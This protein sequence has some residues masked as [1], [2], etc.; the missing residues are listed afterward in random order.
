[1]RPI[2]AA[3]IVVAC[4]PSGD[5]PPRP[6]DATTDGTGGPV[7]T[8]TTVE[9]PPPFLKVGEEG[10]VVV[11]RSHAGSGGNATFSV[12]GVFADRLKGYTASALCLAEGFCLPEGLPAE[13]DFLDVSEE[14]FPPAGADWS[15]VGNTFVAADRAVP[16]VLDAEE[17]QTFYEVRGVEQLA[18]PPYALSLGGEWGDYFDPSAVAMNVIEVTE[19]EPGLGLSLTPG[20]T[21]PFRWKKAGEGDVVLRISGDGFER[22]WRLADDG[23]FDLNVDA[24]P[25][26]SDG[27]YRVSLARWTTTTIDVNGNDLDVIGVSEQPWWAAE[28]ADF[29]TVDLLE[30]SDGDPF[31]PAIRPAYVGVGFS[32]IVSGSHLFDYSYDGVQGSAVLFFYVYDDA[33]VLQCTV[34]YDASAAVEIAADTWTPNIPG[35]EI[36]RAFDVPLANGYTDCPPTDVAFLGTDDIR[37][38]LERVDLFDWGVGIGSK[39]LQATTFL[40][41]VTTVDQFND[42]NPVTSSGWVTPNG[43]TAYETSI[44]EHLEMVPC[45]NADSD[46]PIPAATSEDLVPGYYGSTFLYLLLQASF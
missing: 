12:Y 45:G 19:P 42:L 26:E 21:I 27:E 40:K 28:C 39:S 24:V 6:T 3:L 33:F 44:I 2:V 1:M 17:E 31:D 34:A 9:E 35:E 13:D 20:T 36:Y 10:S 18:D 14:E 38:H 46:N 29:P 11:V 8:D 4:G 41:N 5:T 25:I 22:V 30:G 15:W 7:T 43:V 23:E 37:L 32:G 16:L